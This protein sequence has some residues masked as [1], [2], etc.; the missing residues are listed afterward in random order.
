MC[1]QTGV[2]NEW[3]FAQSTTRSGLL[4][5][6]EIQLVALKVNTKLFQFEVWRKTVAVVSGK[7]LGTS[8]TRE[9]TLSQKHQD[10]AQLCQG[11]DQSFFILFPEVAG[12]NGI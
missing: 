7:P 10:K 8:T 6:Q 4:Q 9:E 3:Y 1:F 12:Y 5:C 2:A 11:Q